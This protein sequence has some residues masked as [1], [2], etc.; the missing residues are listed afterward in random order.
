MGVG[1]EGEKGMRRRHVKQKE[2]CV[3]IQAFSNI[4]V[5]VHESLG[6]FVQMQFLVK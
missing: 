5:G 2:Q 4:K 1:W 6:I 3:L